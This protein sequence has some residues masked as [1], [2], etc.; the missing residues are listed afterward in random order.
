MLDNTCKLDNKMYSKNLK[1]KYLYVFKSL[2]I[3]MAEIALYF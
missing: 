3:K 1:C 2:K